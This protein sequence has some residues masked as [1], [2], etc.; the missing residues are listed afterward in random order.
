MTSP[1]SL[2]ALAAASALAVAPMHA[3]EAEDGAPA[4]E[5]EGR[6]HFDVGWDRGITYRYESRLEG[7]EPTGVLHGAV[8]EGR[9]GGS[10]YLDGG[11]GRGDALSPEDWTA[12]VRRARLYTSGS[13]RRWF[14]TEYKVEF[15]IEDRDLFLNDFYLRW[16]PDRFVDSLR[17]GYFDP[18]SSLQNLLASSSRPLLEVAAPV[19]AFVPGYRLGVEAAGSTS[20]PSL[21]WFLN[22][23]S[24]GE[25]QE[26]GD[27][28]DQP[29]RFG[30]RLIWRPW[31]EPEPD[32]PLLHLGASVGWAPAASGGRV[33][34][35]SRPESFLVDDV[36]DT[37]DLDGA[38][39]LIGTEIIWRDGPVAVQSELLVSRLH[40]SEVG[41]PTFTGAYVQTSWVL[42]GEVRPYDERA[43]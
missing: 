38:N 15:A 11:W 23:S 19:S 4:D 36:V 2:L 40:G 29:L 1:L 7:L 16:R 24:V 13:L 18:P 20:E 21:A 6:F 22:V 5:P 34:H 32:R 31:G 3:A 8:L 37:G 41:N 17:V 12:E 27:N 14:Q 26:V 10:L 43:G 25:S 30:G 28:S 42:T 33:R 9:I 35:R 39:T